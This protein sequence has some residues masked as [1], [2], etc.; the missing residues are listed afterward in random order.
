MNLP[1][2]M[3]ALELQDYGDWRTAL[4][5]VEKPV[6]Q[7]GPNQVLVRIAATPINPTDLGFLQ[8]RYGV[9]RALPTVPGW[10]GSGTVVA[11]GGGLM[12][13]FLLGRRVACAAMDDYDGTW[14]EYTLTSPFR[15]L[16]LRRHVTD[17]QGAMMIVNPLTAWALLSLA[18]HNGHQAVAQTAA[19]SALGRMLMRLGQR[20]NIPMVHIVHRQA[21]VDLLRS[22]GAEYVLSSHKPDFEDKLQELCH[23][24]NV[25]LALDAVAGEITGQLLRAMPRGAQVTVYGTLSGSACQVSPRSLI[26]KNQQVNGFW[27]ARWS[28]RFGPLGLLYTG[29]RIQ[30]LLDNEL[31]TEVQARLPLEKA[32]NGLEMYE[33]GKTKG[34][35]L[36]IP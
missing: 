22:Q 36:F 17:E 8:G 34:K 2:T 28:P 32:R 14:A 23:H 33:R 25:T 20:F 1:T 3:R 31:K 5:V 24:L 35:V 9:R 6:P 10:E 19:A 7:P 15:C 4:K 13:R 26:F 16:P 30:K 11:T 29:W 21:Q 27:L 18:R 12:A